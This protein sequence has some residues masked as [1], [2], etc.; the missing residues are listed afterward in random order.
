MERTIR[1]AGELRL[2]SPQMLRRKPDLQMLRAVF[3]PPGQIL[4]QSLLQLRGRGSGI[5]RFTDLDRYVFRLGKHAGLSSG[6]KLRHLEGR[7]L[8]GA[9]PVILP[10]LESRGVFLLLCRGNDALHLPLLG[11]CSRRNTLLCRRRV[12]GRLTGGRLQTA[13]VRN[14]PGL[15]RNIFPD[16]RICGHGPGQYR[17]Y[18]AKFL[19]LTLHRRRRYGPIHAAGQPYRSQ[20][21]Q[22]HADHRLF[23]LSGFRLPVRRTILPRRRTFRICF[24]LL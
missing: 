4:F 10:L 13:A 20:S 3:Q 23:G 11:Y 5:H 19:R 17:R 6:S 22:I 7:V 16:R 18:R 12:C 8:P 24:G 14:S 15:R 9:V 2:H 21:G 1:R